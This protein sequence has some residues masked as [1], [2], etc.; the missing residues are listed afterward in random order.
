[1]R[2]SGLEEGATDLL[3]AVRVKDI[4]HD[5]GKFNDDSRVGCLYKWPERQPNF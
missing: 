4:S 1:M 2:R 3:G 5:G